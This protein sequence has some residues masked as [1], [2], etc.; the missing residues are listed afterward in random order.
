MANYRMGSIACLN[1][2]LHRTG[3]R[4]DP[5]WERFAPSIATLFSRGL[6]LI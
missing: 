3:K 4:H 2:K 1:V 5:M 6:S